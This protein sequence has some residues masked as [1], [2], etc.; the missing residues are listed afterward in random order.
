MNQKIRALLGWFTRE[1]RLGASGRREVGPLGPFA[2]LPPSTVPSQLG[3][4][5][6]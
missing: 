1:S 5:E 4:D 3:V 6:Q 2:G